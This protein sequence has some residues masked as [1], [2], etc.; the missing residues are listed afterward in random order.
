MMSQAKSLQ[1]LAEKE[2]NKTPYQR[3]LDSLFDL[4]KEEAYSIPPQH[5]RNFRTE[6]LSLIDKYKVCLFCT[7]ETNSF[8]VNSTTVYI[9]RSNNN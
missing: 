7:Y 2:N 3:K 6:A 1:D 9:F 5:Y 4:L 8:N